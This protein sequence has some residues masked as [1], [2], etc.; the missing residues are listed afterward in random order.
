MLFLIL[1][2]ISFH[3]FFTNGLRHNTLLFPCIFYLGFVVTFHL[4]YGRR[5]LF[6]YSPL[7]TFAYLLLL[8][9]PFWDKATNQTGISSLVLILLCLSLIAN[10]ILFAIDIHRMISAFPV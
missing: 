2:F 3:L 4:F 7:Y 8:A 6:L 5:E 10:N 1:I 9:F